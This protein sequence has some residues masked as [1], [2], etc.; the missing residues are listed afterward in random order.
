MDGWF[1]GYR[2]NL[3]MVFDGR[4]F[5]EKITIDLREKIGRMSRKLKLVTIVDP[6][7]SA[8]VMYTKLKAEMAQ[9]LGVDFDIKTLNPK[10]EILNNIKILISKLNE[11]Q[12]VDGIMIQLPF[13][14]GF[15]NSDLEIV[16]A[17]A[18]E[19][20][21]DGL[22]EDSPFRPAV[23]RAVLEILNT[24][25]LTP[26][27]N[28]G[29][30]NERGEVLVIGSKGF[31]GRRLMRVFDNRYSVFGMDKDDFEPEKIKKA[32]V[33]ISC[34]GRE[35]LITGEMVKNGFV[36]IDVGYPKAEFTDEALAK[37]SFYTP[38]PGGVGPVT[39]V[40]LFKNLVEGI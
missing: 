39:V 3:D 36:A 27:L 10:H 26:L 35:G 1:G 12:T 21:V 17:I 38:V 22:R 2:Y 31:V 8:S 14:L 7:N 25:P 37:A 9:R 11:D 40:M 32:D 15:R 23:V 29:E 19:K 5:A 20:D 6:E 4:G 18:R 16:S 33:V 13:F 34:T 24:S 28:L 30:G